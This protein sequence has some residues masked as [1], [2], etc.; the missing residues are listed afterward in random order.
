MML[1]QEQGPAGPSAPTTAADL[2]HG[3]AFP[4]GKLYQLCGQ[5]GV[6]KSLLALDWF[7]RCLLQQG[8]AGLW[9]CWGTNAKA[10]STKLLAQQAR[11]PLRALEQGKLSPT[12]REDLAIA[13]ARLS[14]VPIRVLANGDASL[15]RLFSE[16]RALHEA[17]GQLS[18]LVVDPLDLCPWELGASGQGLRHCVQSLRDLALELNTAVLLVGDLE[19]HAAMWGPW[20]L[21]GKSFLS[22]VDVCISLEGHAVCDE[23][24]DGPAEA[25]PPQRVG[26]TLRRNRSGP[27]GRARLLLDHQRHLVQAPDGLLLLD[28][29]KWHHPTSTA[30]DLTPGQA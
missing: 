18:M 12:A 10:L 26:V 3:A 29:M 30:E 9:C 7:R 28:F 17:H 23:Q 15:D 1:F 4:G 21:E 16:A 6:G 27:L 22:G 25:L 11:V 19:E 2:V 13:H 14:Q 8:G 24:V 5:P 20:H